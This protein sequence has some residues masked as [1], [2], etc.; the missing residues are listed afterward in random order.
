MLM[1]NY[2]VAATTAGDMHAQ[3]HKI[4]WNFLFRLHSLVTVL[5]DIRPKL[6]S[7]VFVMVSFRFTGLQHSLYLYEV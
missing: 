3:L 2:G 7:V 5:T 4:A 1:F 6:S